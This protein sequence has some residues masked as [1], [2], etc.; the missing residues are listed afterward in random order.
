MGRTLLVSFLFPSNEWASNT[1]G[2]EK[3]CGEPKGKSNVIQLSFKYK[4][5][6]TREVEENSSK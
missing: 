4:I 6:P 5:Y 3:I 1:R 2:A